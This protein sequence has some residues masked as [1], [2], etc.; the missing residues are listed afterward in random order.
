MSPKNHDI[1]RFEI[2]DLVSVRGDRDRA[3]EDAC[4]YNRNGVFVIDGATG[5]GDDQYVE[6]YAS[7][8]AWIAQ[9]VR[10]ALSSS[11]DCRT[12]LRHLV[13]NISQQARDRFSR[14]GPDIP[15]YAWPSCSFALVRDSGNGFEFAGLG[16]CSLYISDSSGKT[17]SM[18]SLPELFVQ[19]QEAA[20]V[21]VDRAGG[22]GKAAKL[23]VNGEVLAALRREREK[24]NT[25]E[26]DIWTLGLVPDAADHMMVKR[27]SLEGKV[28]ALLCTDGFADLCVLFGRYRPGELISVSLN[29][30]LAF[31]VAELREMEQKIDPEGKTYPRFKRSDDATAVLFQ[32]TPKSASASGSA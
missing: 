5:L 25:P 32:I 8:A 15:R 7:D 14:L 1:C 28:T 27:L 2:L 17:D 16:D 13:R 30:G 20:R 23:L 11:L 24:Q 9:H 21:F 10:D 6:G 3:N 29:E 22:L 4:G 31:L 19:E 26:N 12:D 18:S